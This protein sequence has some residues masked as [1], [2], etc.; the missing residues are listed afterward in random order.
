MHIKATEHGL[1]LVFE[2][3]PLVVAEFRRV[4]RVRLVGAV[5]AVA[6]DAHIARGAVVV[7]CGDEG[8]VGF[9][10]RAAA[11]SDL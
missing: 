4:S 3:K 2:V 1:F 8:G 11:A 5:S 10:V 6:G 9:G 7:H